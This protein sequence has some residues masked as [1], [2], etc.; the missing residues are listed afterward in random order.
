MSRAHERIRSAKTTQAV[1]AAL[2]E[3]PK[4]NTELNKLSPTVNDHIGFL[5]QDGHH[6]ECQRVPKSDGGEGGKFLYRIVPEDPPKWLIVVE[7]TLADGTITDQILEVEGYTARQAKS[8]ARNFAA[9]TVIK[10]ATLVAS[11]TG[12]EFF[13]A[14]EGH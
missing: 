11:T 1:L 4:L 12:R 6:I 10:E 7:V 14:D 9:R 2:L 8:K 13:T 3:G 5:R